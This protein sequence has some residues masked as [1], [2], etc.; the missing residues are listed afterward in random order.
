M[1]CLHFISANHDQLAFYTKLYHTER[2]TFNL[3]ALRAR[4]VL[5]VCDQS[6]GLE[7]FLPPFLAHF[8]R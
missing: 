2:R 7:A 3:H 8:L 1:Y 5:G 4:S 6:G